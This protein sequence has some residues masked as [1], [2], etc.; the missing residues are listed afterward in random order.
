MVH[1]SLYQR[2]IS[3]ERVEDKPF[4]S[5]DNLNIGHSSLLNM[6]EFAGKK[7]KKKVDWDEPIC[8]SYFHGLCF[9]NEQKHLCKH[10][11]THTGWKVRGKII[12]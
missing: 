7:K 5:A 11:W 1:L 6:S 12:F 3:T 9:M 8:D 4:S 10:I 2:L